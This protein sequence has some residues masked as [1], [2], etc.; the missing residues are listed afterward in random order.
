MRPR[1]LLAGGLALV[2]LAS[3]TACQS[4]QS[5]SA[6]LEDEGSKV[7]LDSSGLKVTK[8]NPDVKVLSTT[9]LS[10][11]EASAVVVEVHNDSNVN[12]VDVPIALD[13]LD[14]KGRSVYRNDAP[15]LEQALVA[16]PYIPAGADALW[17]NDQIL[18][19]GKPATAKV[20]VGV[21][22]NSFSGEL[23]EIEV[24]APEIEAGRIASGQ[25]VNRTGKDQNRLLLYAVARRGN[26]IVAAGRGAF[27]HLKPD[28][29]ELP[30]HVY[31]VGDPSGAKVTITQYP[32][33]HE[34]EQGGA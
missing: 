30:Y 29:K 32:T 34:T 13:V 17:I 15:G 23:P 5:H 27:E 12:L 3:L 7:L 1:P 9:L 31:F 21:S 33:L 24:S 16:I 4:T 26:E 28:T 18:A 14:A 2:A 20:K 11:S 6:Q 10:E 19:S 25:V 8:A 22:P